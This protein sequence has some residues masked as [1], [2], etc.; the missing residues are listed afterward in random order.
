[1]SARSVFA[2]NRMDW[3]LPAAGDAGSVLSVGPA[4]GTPTF[5][6][7][8]TTTCTIDFSNPILANVT[9]RLVQIGARVDVFLSGQPLSVTI[10]AGNPQWGSLINLADPIPAALIPPRNSAIGNIAFQPTG[11]GA[12]LSVQSLITGAETPGSQGQVTL[13][14]RAG[15]AA[16]SYY[17]GGQA[18]DQYTASSIYLGSYSLL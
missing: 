18:A 17:M 13:V 16:G 3:L 9:L 6:Q 11:G 12:S 10:P 2:D 14:Y 1:M 8:F 7:V 4:G 5:S 15:L